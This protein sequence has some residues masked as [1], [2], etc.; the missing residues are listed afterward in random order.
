MPPR[1]SIHLKANLDDVSYK[2]DADA[3]GIITVSPD[4]MVKSKDSLG[5]DMII[6]SAV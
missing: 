5:R 2:L 3:S 1:T 6:V 4:G